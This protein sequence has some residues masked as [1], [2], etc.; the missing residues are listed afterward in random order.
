MKTEG[1]TKS[2]LEEEFNRLEQI[3]DDRKPK[4]VASSEENWI[5]NRYETAI[6]FD[7]NRVILTPVAG[8]DY[9]THINASFVEGYDNSEC[10][11][12][13]QDGV[14]AARFLKDGAG[15]QHCNHCQFVMLSEMGDASDTSCCPQY[16]PDDDQ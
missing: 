16:W 10:F 12:L 7:Q 8:R 1:R 14:D 3:F 2:L 11:I 13:T 5:T 6:A 9:S 4:S 15:A